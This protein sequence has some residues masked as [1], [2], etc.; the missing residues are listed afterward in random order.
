MNIKKNY[1]IIGLLLVA[2]ISNNYIQSI[3]NV[4]LEDTTKQ[5]FSG[6]DLLIISS[7]SSENIHAAILRIPLFAE[8]LVNSFSM[9]NLCL[10]F[11]CNHEAIGSLLSETSLIKCFNAL[12][13]EDQKKLLSKAS[14]SYAGLEKEYVEMI[15]QASNSIFQRSDTKLMLTQLKAKYSKK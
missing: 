12:D 7:E 15:E 3:E 10:Y 8:R 9:S 2:I 4:T 5:Y 14:Q 11:Y 1:L 13:V 6:R